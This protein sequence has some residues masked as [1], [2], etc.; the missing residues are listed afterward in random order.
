[1][2]LGGLTARRAASYQ[3]ESVADAAS[4]RFSTKSSRDSTMQRIEVAETTSVVPDQVAPLDAGGGPTPAL[5]SIQ[6]LLVLCSSPGQKASR[7]FREAAMFHSSARSAW[8]GPSMVG[9][10][11]SGQQHDL[12]DT[13][14]INPHRRGQGFGP[15]CPGSRDRF[16]SPTGFVNYDLP[17]SSGP[18]PAFVPRH[19]CPPR[20][21][22]L[23]R[24]KNGKDDNAKALKSQPSQESYCKCTL[25]R[26][27]L[28]LLGRRWRVL[29]QGRIRLA[30]GLARTLNNDG[31]SSSIAL[32]SRYIASCQTDRRTQQGL[33]FR[34]ILDRCFGQGRQG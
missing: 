25:A 2:K 4:I 12:P 31:L 29:R 26:W 24:P 10:W 8:Q 22:R 9:A 13:A 7:L 1:M 30:R 20:R 3:A 17:P 19:R 6:V 28:V 27:C 16:A 23:Q 33:D 32:M 21:A 18:H 15:S 14:S 11:A 5:Q 34:F